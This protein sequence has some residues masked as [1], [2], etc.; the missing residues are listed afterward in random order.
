MPQGS[1]GKA[2]KKRLPVVGS[3]SARAMNRK[4]PETDAIQRETGSVGL[5]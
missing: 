5:N 1:R 3:K 2:P 4:N